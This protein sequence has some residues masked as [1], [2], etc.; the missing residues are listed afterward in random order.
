MEKDDNKSRERMFNTAQ[1]EYEFWSSRSAT[2]NTLGQQLAL[3]QVK[4]IIN[5]LTNKDSTYTAILESY[6]QE[7]KKFLKAQLQAKDFVKF[8]AT[9]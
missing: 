1:G 5:L 6:N 8:L 7:Q 9:L 2:F 3:P 4:K